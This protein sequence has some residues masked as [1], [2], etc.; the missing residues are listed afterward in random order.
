M[1]GLRVT[2]MVQTVKGKAVGVT[3][4]D[5]KGKPFKKMRSGSLL[6]STYLL[7]RPDLNFAKGGGALLISFPLRCQP[8]PLGQELES[9]SV[10]FGL[11]L[12][13]W[14]LCVVG[15]CAH[16]LC[17]SGCSSQSSK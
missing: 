16:V 3:V 7:L 8:E 6:S 12:S 5:A 1:F 4:T 14:N 11:P 9:F 15:L 17:G 10:L 2:Q 13:L